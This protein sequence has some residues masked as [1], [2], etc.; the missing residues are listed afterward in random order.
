MTSPPANKVAAQMTKLRDANTKYV[1]LLKLAKERIEQ[2]E[3]ELKRLR[4][5]LTKRMKQNCLRMKAN[6]SSA[7]KNMLPNMK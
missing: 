3:Q 5:R 7:E 6:P 2:Q 4:G 1:N